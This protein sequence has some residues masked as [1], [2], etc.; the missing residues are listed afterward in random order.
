MAD[1]NKELTIE[2][3]AGM[4]SDNPPAP[5]AEAKKEG[6]LPAGESKEEPAGPPAEAQPASQS[7]E[8]GDENT[9]SESGT[10]T[11]T[12][13]Q[14]PKKNE[15]QPKGKFAPKEGK[16]PPEGVQKRINKAIWEKHEADRKREAAEREAAELRK[17]LEEKDQAPGKPAG[18]DH[19]P[20]VKPAT[21]S[22]FTEPEPQPPN[23]DDYET[24]SDL[25]KAQAKY[26]K[27][28]AA[29]VTRKTLFEADQRTK[30]DE[31]R[32]QQDEASRQQVEA[33]RRWTER[34]TSYAG[35]N[36]HINEALNHV[37]PF[38]TQAGQAD[39]IMES[40]VGLEIVEYLHDHAAEAIE[41]AKSGDPV[42]VARAI[43]RIEAE[44]LGS[45]KAPPT[46]NPD[47]SLENHDALPDPIRPVGGRSAALGAIDLSDEKTSMEDWSR[48]FKR[49]I[50]AAS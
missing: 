11:A 39:F 22:G 26:A 14:E 40:S 2:E 45:R 10:D 3:M 13:N 5:P 35:K 47:T 12:D 17:K 34:V 7:A 36:P 49:Q 21:T 30:A 37:G 9:S 25:M 38:L 6:A 41:L 4:L 46:N 16:E 50:E 20:S 27:D 33:D 43:G 23:E 8:A 15:D 1:E 44:I 48:E 19:S 31:S 29:W 24:M 42:K 18:S 28:S 32:R